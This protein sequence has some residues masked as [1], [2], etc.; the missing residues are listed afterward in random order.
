MKCRCGK[1]FCYKCG[2]IFNDCECTKIRRLEAERWQEN[3]RRRRLAA[4]R[5]AA[6]TR[7]RNAALKKA[8]QE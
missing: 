2:G 1:D 7:R 4:A 5:R 8:Q 6:E 3:M